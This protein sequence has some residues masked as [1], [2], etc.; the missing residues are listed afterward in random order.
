MAE[1]MQAAPV[2]AFGVPGEWIDARD[3]RSDSAFLYLHGGGHCVGSCQSHRGLVS[4][5]ARA[6]HARALLPE[7]GLAPERPFPAG[8]LDARAAYRYLLAQ[9]YPPQR[10]VVGGESSG[11]NLAL[12]LLLTLRDEGMQMPAG[13]V[14]LSPWTDLLGTGDSVRTRARQ[15]PWLRPAGIELAANRYRGGVAADHPLVSPLYADMHGLP[16]LLIHVGTDEIL[17]DDSTRLAHKA[18]AAA[19]EVTLSV[20]DGM[21]HAFHYF[22]PWAPE[23]RR[24][25]REI[26]EWAA[27]KT[28]T[29]TAND[30]IS[31]RARRF[32]RPPMGGQAQSRMAPAGTGGRMDRRADQRQFSQIAAS[33]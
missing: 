2:N 19:V 26:G 11:G 5:I 31:R 28:G 9:G 15:D 4:H 3:T 8:L 18:A 6:C 23:A 1:A 25:H 22:Y 14:L 16:P 30:S 29:R 13:A 33:G 12:A 10:I 17:L 21:W 32:R 7:Y 24:A 20:W 27:R